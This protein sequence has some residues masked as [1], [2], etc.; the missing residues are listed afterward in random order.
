MKVFSNA[1]VDHYSRLNFIKTVFVA[2]LVLSLFSSCGKDPG[3]T[4]G[5]GGSGSSGNCSGSAKSFTTDVNPI[6]QSTCA[7]SLGCHGTG[8]VTGPGP[9][10]TYTQIFNVRSTI[11]SEVSS[12][13]MPPNGGLSA[14]QKN[15]I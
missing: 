8:S 7:T 1:N 9:L 5:G 10:L 4:T 14:T 15:S 2:F 3:N 13:H 6:I 11:R 12:G